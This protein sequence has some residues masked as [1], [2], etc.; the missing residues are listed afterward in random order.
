MILLKSFTSPPPS[1]AIVM[2][3]LCYAFQEDD[4]VKPKTKEP[5]SL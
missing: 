5:P 3:G 2:E 4:L 1:A